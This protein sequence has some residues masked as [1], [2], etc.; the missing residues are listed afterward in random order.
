MVSTG[1]TATGAGSDG[2]CFLDVGMPRWDRQ[3]QHVGAGSCV[4]RGDGVD[5]PTHVGSQ[6]PLRGYHPVQP[7]QL[8]DMVCLRASFEDERVDEA[9]VEAHPYPHTG[10]RVVGLLGGDEIVELAIEVR[11]RQH[12]QHPSDRLVLAACLVLLTPMV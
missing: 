8:A 2:C 10:L 3:P 6:H 7:A 12:R 1:A 4:A 9:A 5:Q 11:H